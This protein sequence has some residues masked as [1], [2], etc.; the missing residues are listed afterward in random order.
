MLGEIDKSWSLSSPIWFITLHQIAINGESVP[1]AR[2][3]VLMLRISFTTWREHSVYKERQNRDYHCYS[4][5]LLCFWAGWCGDYGSWHGV[6][7]TAHQR[8]SCL[9][10]TGTDDYWA[11][12]IAL[13]LVRQPSQS[14]S[15]HYQARSSLVTGNIVP[16]ALRLLTRLRKRNKP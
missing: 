14:S 13:L 7:S 2:L 10:L 9:F 11:D 1:E 16:E 12:H 8:S 3:E 15:R 5:W 4:L 6:T